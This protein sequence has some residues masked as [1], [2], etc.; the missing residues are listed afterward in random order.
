[1][2]KLIALTLEYGLPI[3]IIACAI[4]FVVG[5]LK[6]CK[7]FSKIQNKGVKKF[8]YYFIDIAL[9]FEKIARFLP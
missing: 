9:S 1:M 3:L 6:I 4:I 2:D 5:L 8:L 7:V